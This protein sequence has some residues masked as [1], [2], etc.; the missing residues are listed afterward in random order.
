[1]LLTREETVAVGVSD[2]VT[3][4]SAP[5]SFKEVVHPERFIDK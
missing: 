4:R 1:M 2:R 3:D 5:F